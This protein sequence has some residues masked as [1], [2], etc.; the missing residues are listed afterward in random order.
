MA[1]VVYPQGEATVTIPANEKIA[2]FS[3]SSVQIYQRVGYPNFPDSWD[4]IETT[5]DGEQYVS[6][7]FSA[8]A[9]LRVNPSASQ[10]FYE[11]G[12]APSVSEP[13]ADITAADATFTITGLAA[14]QGGYVR[15]VGG[16]SSTSGNAGGAAEMLGGQPGATGAGGA[17]TVTGGAGGATSGKGGAVTATGG[18]GTAGNGSGGSIILTPGA[19]HGSGL[20]GGVFN[21]GSF[22]LRKQAAPQTATDT[23]TLTVAQM[24]GGLLVATPTAAAAY[25]MP[26]GTA[27]KA[28]LPTDLAADDSFDIIISNLGGTGDDITLTASTDIT[29]VGDPVVGPIADVATEQSSVGRFRLRFTTG[30]TFIAYRIG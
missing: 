10:A 30:V 6:S 1:T 3:Y 24:L 12:T 11:V 2:V 26:T 22:Q 9:T 27:L 14:A 15:S 29:I 13:Q 17:A 19:A 5:D 8:G 7:A 23:A 20:A 18:A 28:A 16:T 21:R 4:L 25:T